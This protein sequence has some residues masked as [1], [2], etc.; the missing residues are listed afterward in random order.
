MSRR[1]LIL[2]ITLFI[3]IILTVFFKTSPPSPVYL[4]KIA[5]ESI[6]SYF[7]FGEEDNA[8]WLLTKAEK[9]ISEA[10]HLE[11]KNMQFLANYQLGSAKNYQKEADKMITPLKDKINRNYLIDKYNQNN[12]RI[13]ALKL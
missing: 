6:Q 2:S 9:R 7:I 8:F 5:R 1:W 12:D 13:K 3:L 11:S 4:L 10:E